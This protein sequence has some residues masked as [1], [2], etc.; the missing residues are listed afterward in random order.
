MAVGKEQHPAGARARSSSAGPGGLEQALRVARH[1][2][3]GAGVGRVE[4]GR[5]ADDA[6]EL[7]AELDRRTEARGGAP[8]DS[9]APR[10]EKHTSRGCQPAPMK[11][12]SMRKSPPPTSSVAWRG[13]VAPSVAV[14][15][16][17][18]EVAHLLDAAPPSPRCEGGCSASAPRAR[19]AASA[20]RA[21]AARAD[22]G[23][24]AAATRPCAGRTPARARALRPAR[25]RG[26]PRVPESSGRD[27]PGS[28]VTGRPRATAPGASS[29]HCA[30]TS[31]K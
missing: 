4:V 3:V 30:A 18:D 9:P 11:T 27:R 29:P 28:A 26:R 20:R 6:V 1:Y 31:A 24:T 17:H 2:G 12:Y 15:A 22:P 14:P 19:C 16:D 10:C 5:V 7:V 8:S 25:A 23:S 21:P 13:D